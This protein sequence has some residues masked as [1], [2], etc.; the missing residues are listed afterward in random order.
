MKNIAKNTSCLNYCISGMGERIFTF[1]NT[2]EGKKLLEACKMLQSEND[3]R[4]QEVLIAYNSYFMVQGAVTALKLPKTQESVINFM[5]SE[6]FT[7]LHN[8]VVDAIQENFQY[9]MNRLSSKQ[10]KRL[11]AL[12][13]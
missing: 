3:K 2:D 4:I 10:K 12:F 1:A 8:E 5:M 11:E 6:A 13:A 9:L 7:K